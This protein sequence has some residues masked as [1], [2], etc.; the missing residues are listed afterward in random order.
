[1][2]HTEP[3]NNETKMKKIKPNIRNAWFTLLDVIYQHT[4]DVFK[5]LYIQYYIQYYR[6]SDFSSS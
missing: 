1:M 5:Y 6:K 2:K 3:E 4:L